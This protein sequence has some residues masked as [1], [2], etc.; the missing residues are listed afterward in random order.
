MANKTKEKP[1]HLGRG[2]QALLSPIT[3]EPE[4]V[5]QLLS[6]DTTDANFPQDKKLRESIREI[7]TLLDDLKHPLLGICFDTGHSNLYTSVGDELPLCGD[8]L[9]GLHIH[10]NLQQK[11]NHFAPFRGK[12]DWSE[13]AQALVQ[14]GYQGPLLIEA[15]E[16]EESESREAFITACARAYRDLLELIEQSLH[17][18]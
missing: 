2:L 9:L 13:F 1:K 7:N 4:E 11:D 16:R 3:L 8:R 10:D 14:T 17:K 12:I 6:D 18:K 15:F 5:D